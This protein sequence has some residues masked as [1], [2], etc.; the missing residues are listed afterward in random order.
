[1]SRLVHALLCACLLTLWSDSQGSP[2][3]LPFSVSTLADFDEPW[4][5]TMTFLPDGALLVTEKA[6]KE[7][8]SIRRAAYGCTKWGR[9]ADAFIGGLASRALIGVEF[10][11]ESAGP[12]L[13]SG[14]PPCAVYSPAESGSVRRCRKRR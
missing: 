3:M 14:A 9:A 1:V 13:L 8:R 12:A 11:G 2:S 5:M 7:S 6:G 10:S 4:A